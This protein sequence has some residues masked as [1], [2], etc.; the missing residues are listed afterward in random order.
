M[1]QASDLSCD[2][3]IIGA[4]TAGLG[5]ARRA[6][7]EGAH[8]LLIDDRFAGTMCA[9]VG[10]M[11]SKLLIAASRA[12]HAARGAG[13]F[14]IQ[15]G[16]VWVDGPAIM[17]RVRAER[18]RF[19]AETRKSFDDFPAG[20]MIKAR[21]RFIGPD[22]LSFDD[23]RTLQAKAI[24]IATGG[25]PAIPEEFSALG[26]LC[27]THESVF[28]LS[29]LPSSIAVMGAGPIGLELAQAFA[30]LG[31][32]TALF[33]E[34][35]TVGGIEDAALQDV[36]QASL[37]QDLALHLGLKTSARREGDKAL[38]AWRGHAEGTQEFEK[39]LI[40]T[41]RPPQLRDLDLGKTGIALDD[42]GTPEYDRETMQCGDAPIF[43]AGDVAVK[44][45]VLHEASAEGQIAGRNAATFPHVT[46]TPRMTPFSLIFSQPALAKVG[47]EPTEDTLVGK[48]SYDDQGRARIEAEALGQVHLYAE[49]TRGR[50]T[51]AV[52][53][54]PGAEHMAHLLVQAV[55]H[56]LTASEMLAQPFYHPTLEEG[57][58]PA[59]RQICAEVPSS[60]DYDRTDAPGG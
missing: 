17:A 54:C 18:D 53:F 39:V 51:G 15:T 49:P 37:K 33:D 45:P 35:E 58:K 42:H 30:R 56:G 29:D 43:I 23:G 11:P 13:I 46:R 2:V 10:C 55:A 9:N 26:E 14:G 27:L 47:A 21:A 36:I 5:A 59:L 19:A 16:A 38:I 6:L 40:A 22:Q 52:L 1:A 8:V 32:R 7:R 57:L 48:A 4:G 60:G 28:E 31:V 25:K 24:I 34:A 12:A 44:A 41:G 50:L 20:T 3:A